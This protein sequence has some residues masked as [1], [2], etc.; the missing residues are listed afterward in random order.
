MKCG[1]LLMTYLLDG[2]QRQVCPDYLPQWEAMR[3]VKV[4]SCEEHDLGGMP[5]EDEET[6]EA[7][8]ETRHIGLLGVYHF[9]HRRRSI[10]S[11]PGALDKGNNPRLY[12]LYLWR[13]AGPETG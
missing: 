2:R 9:K 8:F 12:R 13:M 5:D 6:M 1:E 11:H 10:A 7:Q 3:W 4:H